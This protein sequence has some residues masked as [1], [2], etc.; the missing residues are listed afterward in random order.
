V[1]AHVRRHAQRGHQKKTLVDEAERAATKQRTR[2]LPEGGDFLVADMNRSAMGAVDGAQEVQKRRLA[3]AAGTHQ[4]N[5][6]SAREVEIHVFEQQVV[7]PAL[8]VAITQ[9]CGFKHALRPVFSSS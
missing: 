8:A 4:R 5:T 1:A 9:S 7:A 3:T 2:R 6:L